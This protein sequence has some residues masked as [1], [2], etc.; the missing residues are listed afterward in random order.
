MVGIPFS[1][2]DKIH[3][4]IKESLLLGRRRKGNVA[5]CFHS[6]LQ[7]SEGCF[8]RKSLISTGRNDQLKPDKLLNLI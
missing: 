6:S 8:C 7:V 2:K 1:H 4:H 3:E 5:R